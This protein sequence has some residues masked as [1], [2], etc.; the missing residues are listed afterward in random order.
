MLKDMVVSWLKA[1]SDDYQG[2]TTCSVRDF[3]INT[4]DAFQGQ[5]KEII[6]INCVRSNKSMS[7]KG[8]LGFLVDERRMNV[9]ITRAKHFLFVIGNKRTLS[10]NEKWAGFIEQCEKIKD[11]YFEFTQPNS[12]SPHSLENLFLEN[13]I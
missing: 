7:L 6:I 5:E 13:Q 1:K 4:V 11:G 8:S 9:A 3:D 10:K 2:K 12:Y